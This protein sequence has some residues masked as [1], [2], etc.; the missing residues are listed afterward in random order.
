[1]IDMGGPPVVK[2]LAGAAPCLKGIC[3]ANCVGG[4]YP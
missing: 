3:L 1:L 2:P 4:I